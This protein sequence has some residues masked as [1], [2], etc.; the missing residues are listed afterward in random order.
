MIVHDQRLGRSDQCA[1][2]G[3]QDD[4]ASIEEVQTR[5]ARILYPDP[6]LVSDPLRFRLPMLYILGKDEI[7]KNLSIP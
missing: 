6:D 2:K 3:C 1:E 4:W 5:V 7:D